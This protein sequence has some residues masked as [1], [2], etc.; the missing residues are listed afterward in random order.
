MDFKIYEEDLE[1][2]P[3]RVIFS[4][5]VSFWGST[6][7]WQLKAQDQ[8]R[9][10]VQAWYLIVLAQARTGSSSSHH[11]TGLDSG[12]AETNS[13]KGRTF[14]LGSAEVQG[15]YWP[16][17]SSPHFISELSLLTESK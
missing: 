1:H 15:R 12:T 6:S 14:I 9:L 4:Y 5:F 17:L 13:N 3:K 10:E 2:G 11:G 7:G 16:Y 8:H